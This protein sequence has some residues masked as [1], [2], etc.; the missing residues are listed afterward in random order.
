[1]LLSVTYIDAMKK[2]PIFLFSFLSLL[3]SAQYHRDAATEKQQ[4]VQRISI[5]YVCTTNSLNIRSTPS[6]NAVVLGT[7]KSGE[8]IYVYSHANDFAAISYKGKV[9]YVSNKFIRPAKSI[10]TTPPSPASTAKKKTSSAASTSTIEPPMKPIPEEAKKLHAGHETVEPIVEEIDWGDYVVAV[11][12]GKDY[13]TVWFNVPDFS[14]FYVSSKTYLIAQ[15]GNK[16]IKHKVKLMGKATEDDFYRYLFDRDVKPNAGRKYIGLI[17]D[18]I[19]PSI[20]V[21]TVRDE[22]KKWEWK[23][24]HLTPQDPNSE[25]LEGRLITVNETGGTYRGEMKNGKKEGWGEYKRKN[26]DRYV[27][28]WKNDRFNGQGILYNREHELKIVGTWM[29]GEKDGKISYYYS[30][31]DEKIETYTEGVLNGYYEYRWKSPKYRLVGQYVNG[32]KE[33]VW[34]HYNANGKVDGKELYEKGRSLGEID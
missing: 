11:T 23:N 2:L 22:V 19:D 1:M 4:L 8:L 28:Y 26:G 5:P 27:G 30:I 21:I 24:I 20:T 7:L 16:K 9:G 14:T 12:Q 33:G 18:E 13:T 34:K 6:E 17:F 3:A 25:T 10:K 31:G 29:N 32:K 15:Q